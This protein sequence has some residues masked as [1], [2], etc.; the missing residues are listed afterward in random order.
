MD[1]IEVLSPAGSHESLIAGLE[2]GSDAVYFGLDTLN[3]R[4][5]AINFTDETLKDTVKEVHSFNSK[6]YLTLNIDVAER[7]LGHA[8]R[9]IAHAQECE[10]DALIIRDPSLLNVVKYFPEI[11]FHFSTQAGI[12]S[13]ADIQMSKELGVT[14]VVLARELSLEEIIKE[15]SDP[16]METEVF[17]QG[18]MCFSFSGRCLLS[19]WGGGKSGNR[20]TCASP[21]RVPWTVDKKRAGRPL[22]S[23][24]LALV[25][26]IPKLIEAGVSSLKIEGRLKK[27]EWVTT[28]TEIYRRAVDG[29]DTSKLFD[30]AQGLGNYTGRKL[31]SDLLDGNRSNLTSCTGRDSLT[32]DKHKKSCSK[33]GSCL[34]EEEVEK[35][36]N[37]DEAESADDTTPVYNDAEEVSANYNIAIN[38]TKKGIELIL[39]YANTTERSQI[40]IS[41]I[42]RPEKALLMECFLDELTET[43]IQ[44]ALPGEIT[45]DCPDQLLMQKVVKSIYDTI[46]KFMYRQINT[47]R[48]K[49]RHTLP[50]SVQQLLD[51]RRSGDCNALSL[52]DKINTVRI[53]ARDFAEFMDKCNASRVIIE[54]AEPEQIVNFSA[55]HKN[56][57]LI[58]ALPQVFFDEDIKYVEEQI[59]AA[60]SANCQIEANNWGGIYLCRKHDIPFHTGY[61]LP[62]L[63]SLTALELCKL[64]AR[65]TTYT[66]E[67]D[68]QKFEDISEHTN[69][70]LNLTVY[71]RSPLMVTRFEVNANYIGRTF[72]DRRQ[73]SMIPEIE[74]GLVVFRSKD[75]FNI[76]YQKNSGIKAKY[77]TI[78]LVNAPNPSKEYNQVMSHDGNVSE[79]LFNYDRK[80]S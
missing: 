55:K 66:L 5:G 59:S 56:S 46:S 40:S 47:R 70:E 42:R 9:M 75:P 67:G 48:K 33:C 62:V 31:M 76:A 41:K 79:Y 80:L 77:L 57:E 60:K 24:D 73:L 15:S 44:G 39:N 11:E 51:N 72:E 13:F 17:C 64:G 61:G 38:S 20:G 74:R 7:E 63:N 3:A 30:E 49:L 65:S 12:S 16:E 68:Q 37:T 10:V 26:H 52:G 58:F 1:R 29:S 54:N 8:F 78:D 35:E 4:R 18:A 6:A 25:K 27:P 50:D 19:S 69:S 32:S 21:C 23:H 22:S 28:A 71:S 43:P 34:P 53:Q 45:T 14:R 36:Y 2:A